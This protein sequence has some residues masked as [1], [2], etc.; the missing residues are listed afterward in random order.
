M[1]FWGAPKKMEDH[2]KRACR[3]ALAIREAVEADNRLRRERGLEPVRMRIG[4]HTG[5]VVVGNIGAPDRVNYTIVGDPVNTA[6]RLE[7]LG[8]DLQGEDEEV[9]ILVSASTAKAAGAEFTFETTGTHV[10]RGR[11]RGVEILHLQAGPVLQP[12]AGP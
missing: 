1:A 9:C 2:A 6:N 11:A 10:L 8:K 4:I 7:A 12:E 3:A 5:E